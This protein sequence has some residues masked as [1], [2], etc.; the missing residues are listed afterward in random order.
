MTH[1]LSR[2]AL[3]LPGTL[4]MA[5]LLMP[6]SAHAQ[7]GPPGTQNGM[8]NGPVEQPRPEVNRPKVLPPALPGAST[9]AAPTPMDRPPSD[10][11]P[12]EA[13]F[14][15]INRGDITTARDAIGRGADMHAT[16]VLGLTPTELS[17]DLGRN[18]ITF[19]LLSLRGASGTGG[20]RAKVANTTAPPAH[21]AAK[22]APSRPAPRPAPVAAAPRPP[23]QQYAD[24]PGTPVPQAG[25]LGFGGTAR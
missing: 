25:F 24:V 21:A 3:V 18:D 20:S 6:L 9:T 12:T 17:V 5:A 10:M 8:L 4:L 22:P 1:A 7:G 13:L 2:L 14:D 11:R 23:Q 16:N 15:A 19:L